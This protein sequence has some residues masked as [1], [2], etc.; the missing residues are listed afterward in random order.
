MYENRFVSVGIEIVNLF[1]NFNLKVL[2]ILI[3]NDIKRQRC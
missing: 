3:V 1:Q 2:D